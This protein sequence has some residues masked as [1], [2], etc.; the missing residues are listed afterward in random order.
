M[1]PGFN[2]TNPTYPQVGVSQTKNEKTNGGDTSSLLNVTVPSTCGVSYQ[3]DVYAQK[4]GTS[5]NIKDNSHA[6]DALFAAG[7][8]G[9]DGAQDGTYLAGAGGNPGNFGLNH[10]WKF[11]TNAACPP[12][13]V[14]LP[15]SNVSYTYSAD[16]ANMGVIT[17]TNPDKSKYTDTLCTP[18]YVTATSWT[19]DGPGTWPQTFHYADHVNG[20]P[21]TAEG[22]V[23][24]NTVGTYSYSAP[25]TCGQGDIYASFTQNAATLTPENPGYLNGPSSPFTEHFLSDMGFSGPS[26]TYHVDNSNCWTPPTP[27]TTVASCTKG[28]ANTITA[29]AVLGGVWTATDGHGHTYTS[30]V[31]GALSVN[32]VAGYHQYTIT[33]TDGSST[34]AY[35]VPTT[36]TYYTPAFVNLIDCIPVVTPVEPSPTDITQCGVDGSIDIPTTTGVN[37]YLNADL[38]HP[39]TGTLTGLHGTVY[40]TALPAFGY[41]F[42]GILQFKVYKFD[43]GDEETCAATVAIGVCTVTNATAFEAVQLT[44]DN[45]DSTDSSTFE[46]NGTDYVVDGGET[47]VIDYNVGTAGET[48]TVTVNGSPLPDVVVPPFDGCSSVVAGDPSVTPAS[49]DAATNQLGADS[50]ITVDEEPG[51]VYAIT[52]PAGFTPLSGLTGT[53]GDT[54]VATGVPAGP[55]VISVTAAPGYT[56]ASDTATSWPRDI[57]VPPTFCDFS[58][59]TTPASCGVQLTSSKFTAATEE[60]GT[61]TVDLNDNV[62]YTAVNTDTSVE[63]VLTDATT[64]MPDGHYNVVVTLSATGV[65]NGYVLDGPVSFGPFDLT[66]D[67]PPPGA[68][69]NANATGTDAV[70]TSGTTTDGVITLFH[71]GSQPGAVTY[72]VTND[73]THAVV[74]TGTGSSDTLVHVGAGH[75]TV[76][77][78]PTNPADGLSPNPANTASE[79][80]NFQ[81]FP[82]D[83][84]LTS[85]DCDGDLAFTGGTI[86]WLGFVLAGGMLFLGF[87][88]LYMRR[89]GNRT[90]E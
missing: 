44:L 34:D 89:R 35:T 11:V 25:I 53:G 12:P 73:S 83:I 4:F 72:T 2:G 78:V 6:L 80:D 29:P 37:Y 40:I 41:K 75:Y 7:L 45:T 28:S 17:V 84:S 18:F 54:V 27:T 24:I 65:S 55:Y 26:P 85:S 51:L 5:P 30:T 62:V 22:N 50:T 70:C 71:A 32:P 58:V 76:K 1:A 47:Q 79:S 43:L 13:L 69:D 68:T 31:D 15:D 33:L 81:T 39:V 46:V 86:A 88:L 16:D 10:A 66:A 20:S 60:F 9:P 49:C 67:C 42:S 77:A 63:T 14:C 23:A 38:L 74:Y 36:T 90:A 82:I 8:A 56:L 64:T 21:V 3:I 48:F 19:F 57:S 87:A 59:S 52:G 61:I